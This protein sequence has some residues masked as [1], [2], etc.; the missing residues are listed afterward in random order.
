MWKEQYILIKGLDLALAL[1][2]LQEAVVT[3]PD[4]PPGLTF[5]IIASWR[6]SPIRD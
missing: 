3:L 5:S 2:D 1:V 4:R 6:P